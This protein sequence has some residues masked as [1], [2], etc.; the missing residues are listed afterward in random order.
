MYEGLLDLHLRRGPIESSLLLL[1]PTD[2][3]PSPVI[4]T[5]ELLGAPPKEVC[6]SFGEG[7]W[8]PVHGSRRDVGN[9]LSSEATVNESESSGGTSTGLTYGRAVRSRR[10]GGATGGSVRGL[11]EST[12]HD[13]GAVY[14]PT[15]ITEPMVRSALEPLIV[16]R[17]CRQRSKRAGDSRV[18]ASATQPW[19]CCFPS[20]GRSISCG[21][22]RRRVG[23]CVARR[24]L[25][26][27]CSPCRYASAAEGVPSELLMPESREERVIWAGAL[28]S[29]DAFTVSTS[30]PLQSKWRSCRSGWRRRL[31]LSRS[32][33]SI[34]FFAVETRS[35]VRTSSRFARGA[36]TGKATGIRCSRPC[37]RA[38]LR[39]AVQADIELARLTGRASES[40][41]AAR[42]AAAE[43][44]TA[45]LSTAADLLVAV[46]ACRW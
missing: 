20:A 3:V 30:T 23:L 43:T 16:G 12:T 31:L 5:N 28:S 8:R 45:R 9:V 40:G 14:T 35:L 27:P 32:P 42:A 26:A 15:T 39:D 17:G 11:R 25:R 36:S 41:E 6:G 37:S 21:A 22:A 18:F 13:Q 29:N 34:T 24:R 19:V 4:E 7:D 33:S 1:T 10:R 46:V 38:R 44:A 2:K